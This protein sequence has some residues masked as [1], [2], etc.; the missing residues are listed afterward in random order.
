[1]QPQENI[2]DKK[3]TVKKKM[4]DADATDF[5]WFI[6]EIFSKMVLGDRHEIRK[7]KN[8]SKS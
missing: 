7:Q 6:V 5:H 1:M 3:A 8:G 4:T 2:P